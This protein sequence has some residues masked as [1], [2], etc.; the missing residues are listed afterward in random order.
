MRA[1]GLR[2]I[3]PSLLLTVAACRAGSE[4]GVLARGTIEV[5][6]IDLA[7]LVAARVV[8]IRFDEGEPV[9]A[10]DTVAIL[11]QSDLPAAIAA[12]EARVRTAE[13]VLRDLVAGS[14]PEEI[15]RA[16]AE[17]DMAKAEAE[18]T[19]RELGRLESLAQGG[20]VSR[21]AVDDA[22]SAARVAEERRRAAEEALGLL[23][24]GTRPE[25]IRA[26]RADLSSARASL[27]MLRS[28]Q[29]DLVLLA[30]VAGR[31]LRR[32]AEPGEVLA[33]NAPVITLGET[34]RPYVRVYVRAADVAHLRL[35][36]PVSVR[37]DGIDRDAAPGRIA[38]I[39]PRAEFTPRV[40]LT[41]EE[42][43]DLMFAVKVELTGDVSGMHPGLWAAVRRAGSG[44]KGVG[45]GR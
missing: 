29:G 14:R 8:A 3:A 27:D 2:R 21:Q 28:R 36:D 43:A 19:A 34:G 40:A 30:P 9:A 22:T 11:V 44:E 10:G 38:A 33:P 20:A 4:E 37:L 7:P 41:E 12:Q 42:R 25:R 18:R 6:E 31:V 13:A 16:E 35:G 5:P 32:L 23:R 15:R 26:A 1:K 39:S 17:V 24:A 45:R